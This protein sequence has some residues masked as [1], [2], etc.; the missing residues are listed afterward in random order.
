M[1]QRVE[2]SREFKKD[3]IVIASGQTASDVLNLT[4][5]AFGSVQHPAAITGT[6]KWQI[7]IDGVTWTDAGSITFSAGKT[8]A[9]PDAVWNAPVARILASTGQAAERTFQTFRKG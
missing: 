3:D 4:R 5:F 2:I 9:I 1:S 7:S 6:I 8:E